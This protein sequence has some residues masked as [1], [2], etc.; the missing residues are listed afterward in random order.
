MLIDSGATTTALSVATAQAAGIDT[1]SSPFPAV[2]NTANGTVMAQTGTAAKI[3][4][5]S[6]EARDVGVVVSRAFGDGD[7]LG[8]N[9][10]SQLASWRVEGQTLVLTP[11]AP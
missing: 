9:F 7:V 1:A 5:G 11:T 3:T 4:I 6:I 2:L 10:L 8:M